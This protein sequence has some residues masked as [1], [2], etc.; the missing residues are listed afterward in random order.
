[1]WGSVFQVRSYKLL[2]MVTFW[3]F[4]AALTND[5]PLKDNNFIIPYSCA[6]QELGLCSS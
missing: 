4:T 5:P 6:A 3:L 1:M 2:S